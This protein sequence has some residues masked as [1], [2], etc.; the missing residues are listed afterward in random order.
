[1]CFNFCVFIINNIQR[2]SGVSP[3]L[4]RATALHVASELF[5]KSGVIL[6]FSWN[7]YILLLKTFSYMIFNFLLLH[8]LMGLCFLFFSFYFCICF[9]SMSFICILKTKKMNDLHDYDKYDLMKRL[10]K[11][12]IFRLEE[13]K[14]FHN[15]EKNVQNR[16][17]QIQDGHHM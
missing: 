8:Q 13:E 15:R 11:K 16:L 7:D 9:V 17:I 5:I 4:G 10:N 12:N 3:D 14:I 6:F 2:E 1:M